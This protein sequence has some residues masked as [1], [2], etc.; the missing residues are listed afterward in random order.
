M[1]AIHHSHRNIRGNNIRTGMTKRII[2]EETLDDALHQDIG[3]GV[4][5][6]IK[7][8]ARV[9]QSD[10]EKE[11]KCTYHETFVGNVI[12]NFLVHAIN[13]EG[14]SNKEK[15]IISASILLQASLQVQEIFKSE[16][17]VKKTLN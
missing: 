2:T 8:L 13:F 4:R 14:V 12:S 9:L 3:R 7:L 5:F 1:V 10:T 6:L 16:K 15:L 17:S 11:V